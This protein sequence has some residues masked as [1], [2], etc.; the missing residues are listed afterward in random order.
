MQDCNICVEK[1]N[2]TIRKE[3]ICNKCN[4]SCCKQCFK[5]YILDNSHY[6]SCM[7]CKKEFN[8]KDLYQIVGTAFINKEYVDPYLFLYYLSNNT[9]LSYKDIDFD[10]SCY[11]CGDSSL[12]PAFF[13]KNNHFVHIDCCFE[14]ILVIIKPV[15]KTFIIP[16]EPFRCDY[17]NTKF[18]TNE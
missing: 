14:Q 6:F 13:C 9:L 17:C 10:S 8:R 4:F 7:S 16:N 5:K 3:I 12:K 1:Y 15:Y 18:C 2:K 11:I